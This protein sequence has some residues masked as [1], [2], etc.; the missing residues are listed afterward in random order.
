MVRGFLTTA[1]GDYRSKLILP[2]C[3][4]QLKQ[5]YSF[6][7]V[8]H[9][10]QELPPAVQI[11][12]STSQPHYNIS[13]N[14]VISISSDESTA[15]VHSNDI[16][17]DDDHNAEHVAHNENPFVEPTVQSIQPQ[18][19][20]IQ[21]EITER[22]RFPVTFGKAAEFENKQQITLHFEDQV[23]L[24]ATLRAESSG[25]DVRTIQTI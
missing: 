10:N 21:R 7:V 19:L 20:E 22:F 9:Q 12:E 2:Q 14:E 6:P 24:N 1:V 3:Y 23:F 11:D 4:D 18:N 5:N 17:L 8:D 16:V 13:E 25:K 15:S